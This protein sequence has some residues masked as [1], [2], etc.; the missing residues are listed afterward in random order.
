MK[1]KKKG[2]KSIPKVVYVNWG[3]LTIFS[4][5]FLPKLLG[6]SLW[7]LILHF[8]DPGRIISLLQLYHP[9]FLVNLFFFFFS[10]HVKVLFP[11]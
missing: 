2:C 11:T 4:L 9:E 7:Y 10:L 8:P 5:G 6:L 1:K 3:K